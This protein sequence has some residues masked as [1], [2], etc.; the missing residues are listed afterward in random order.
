LK[1][2]LYIFLIIFLDSCATHKEINK[3]DVI[4]TYELNVEAYGVSKSIELQEDLTFKYDWVVGLNS[5]ATEGTWNLNDNKIIFF[6][7]LGVSSKNDKIYKVLKKKGEN[8]DSVLVKILDTDKDPVPFVKCFKLKDS[9]LLYSGFTDLDGSIKLSSSSADSI[10]IRSVDFG[11]V[12]VQW[13]S[14]VIYYEIMVKHIPLNY[15]YFENE[16]WIFKKSR[17]YDPTIANKM[18]KKEYYEKVD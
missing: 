14:N 9:T 16:K 15:K 4:G 3:E 12:K 1:I 5:G 10:I 18:F 8:M 6:S 17:L 13:E 2:I 11:E 7:E